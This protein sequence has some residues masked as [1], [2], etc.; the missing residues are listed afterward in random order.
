MPDPHVGDARRIVRGPASTRTTRMKLASLLLSLARLPRVGLAFTALAPLG[1]H[2]Q[3]GTGT[4]HG[5]VSDVA[6][7]R[8][9]QGAIV[10]IANSPYRDYTD[11]DGR[12]SLTGLPAGSHR[13]LVEYVGLDPFSTTVTVSSGSNQTVNAAL[14]STVLELE[15]FTVAEQARG[16]SLAINQ[17]KTASGI[18]NIVSEETFGQMIDGNIGAALQRLPG[19]SV[20]EAQDGSQGAF[21]IR[22]IAGEFNSFQIDGNRAP[23]SGGSRAFDSRQLAADGITT[24]EVIKA[25]TPDRDGDAIG[26]IVN[27]V[28]RSAFQRDGRSVKLKASGVLNEDPNKWG[29]AANLTYSDLFSVGG[30]EKNLGISLTASSYKTDRYSLN[31]DIDWVRVTPENNPQL[32]LGQYDDLGRPVWFMEATHWE[33]DTRVT[34]TYGLSGSIDFRTDENNSFY[35]RPLYSHFDRNGIK[36]ETDIDID[37]RFQDAV[38]GRKTYAELTPTYGRGTPGNGGSRGSMGWIGTDD[39]RE[40]DLYSFAFGGRHERESSLLTYDLY[41]SRSKQTVLSDLELNMLMEPT[42]PWMLFEYELTRPWTGEARINILSGQ[43]PRDLSL[44]SE[45]ELI[46]E[47]SVKT[48]DVVSARIDWEKT[49]NLDRSLF[50]VKTGAKYRSSEPKFDQTAIVN[51]MDETFPY[52]TVLE[53]TDVVL[54][55]KEKYWDVYPRRGLELL[56]TNPGLFE[57]EEEDTLADSNLEDYDA[58]EE[59]SA[60]YVMGTLQAGRHTVIGGVRYERNEWSNVNKRV[61]YL[62]G[63]GSVVTVNN[64]DSYSHWLPSLHFRHALSDNLILR[65]SYNRSYGRPRIGELTLGRFIDE[66]GNIE[67]GNPNLKPAT[68]DN[69]DVQLE[70]YTR[71]GGLYSIGVFYK[72]I[73]DFTFTEVYEFDV[74]DANGI[75]VRAPG[76]DFEYERPVN[77]T[78]AKNYGLELIARQRLHFLPGPLKGFTAGVSATFTESDAEYPNRTDRDDLSLEGFSDYIFTGALEYARGNFRARLDYRYRSDYIEGLGDSIESDEYYA[79]EERVDAEVSYRLRDGLTIFANGT[80]LTDRPQ[81]SYAGYGFFVED[82]SFAGRKYTFGLEYS[83]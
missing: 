34:K 38:G 42:S 25:P 64:G 26:G 82:T 66:D 37:T 46:D 67:D 60:A 47:T 70:Y 55:A 59:T 80:N 29:H 1:L 41:Y 39:E 83:F 81:V 61:S 50:K 43:D 2:A 18:V 16:Q 12:F 48:E 28:S 13:L 4:V 57:L 65:E 15:T 54:F 31:A 27:V 36:F 35:F 40:N 3:A 58:K 62:N 8:S 49:F 21:N 72:D 68:A 11:A 69:F 51:T 6:T 30:G 52:R 63:V 20:D 14:K 78:S 73:K 32:N 45:G 10:Q 53:P 5:R 44:M 17:Q 56:R 75:P 22:G 71:N 24:I 33:Y 76:G 77:G 19:I 74:L 79:A 23:T 9:L 7:G